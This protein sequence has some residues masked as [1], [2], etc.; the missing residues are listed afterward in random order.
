MHKSGN[1]TLATNIGLIRK[2]RFLHV[3]RRKFK[4]TKS[5]PG[6]PDPICC[7]LLTIMNRLS[8]KRSCLRV[9][10]MAL[11]V[12]DVNGT[13]YAVFSPKKIEKSWIPFNSS[14]YRTISQSDLDIVKHWGRSSAI[15]PF[16]LLFAD[17]IQ[18]STRFASGVI[19]RNT[20]L[21][22]ISLN[23][24]IYSSGSLPNIIRMMLLLSPGSLDCV[25][26]PCF[27]VS[28]SIHDFFSW[29]V[30]PKHISPFIKFIKPSL[31]RSTGVSIFSLKIM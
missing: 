6:T 15:Y 4:Q 12:A 28:S 11:A 3:R 21:D 24:L 31:V 23:H 19:G 13:T 18:S 29:I 17:G 2:G 26:L 30:G 27:L 14:S 10:Q 9:A 5:K 20:S 7:E 25:C 1:R 16:L 8:F 22:G